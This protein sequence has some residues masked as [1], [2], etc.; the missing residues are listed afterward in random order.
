MPVKVSSERY[1]IRRSEHA[2]EM[3]VLADTV[4]DIYENFS[5]A[6]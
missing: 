2:P 5:F 1:L 3:A 6:S 4:I